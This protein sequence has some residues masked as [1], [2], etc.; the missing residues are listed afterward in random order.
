MLKK[1]YNF[2]IFDFQVVN[3][4]FFIQNKTNFFNQNLYEI[5][6]SKFASGSKYTKNTYNIKRLKE[7]N[8][9]VYNYT[10]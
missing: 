2:L 6:C 10:N 5:N 1:E 4:T 7:Y 3:V 9:N 8:E